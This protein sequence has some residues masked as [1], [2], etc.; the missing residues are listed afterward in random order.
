MSLLKNKSPEMSTS[1]ER[2][3]LYGRTVE[4][5]I[6]F[7]SVFRLIIWETFLDEVGMLPW[8]LSFQTWYKI[9]TFP[10]KNFDD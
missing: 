9:D 3:V 10:V 8:Y 7:S 1:A 4:S 2:G 5:L 6:I